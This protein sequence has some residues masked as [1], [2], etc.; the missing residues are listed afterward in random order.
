MELKHKKIV[1]AGDSEVGYYVA[2]NLRKHSHEVTIIGNGGEQM[3]EFGR[4]NDISVVEG[5]AISPQTQRDAKV[6]GC[7]Y[8]VSV[9]HDEKYNLLACIIAHN[10]GAK[11][12]VA[13]VASSEMWLGTTGKMFHGIGVNHMICPEDEAAKEI[14]GLLDFDNENAANLMDFSGG[15]LS[16]YKLCVQEDSEAANMQIVEVM[17]RNPSLLAHAVA[18]VRQGAETII[19][20]P[21]FAF[22]A[23]DQVYVVSSPSSLDQVK[24]LIGR[25]NES[26]SVQ[27]VI[28]AG[29]GRVGRFAAEKLSS[30]KSLKII[31][32]N[33]S[34]CQ[35]LAPKYPNVCVLRGDATDP[36]FLKSEGIATTDAFVA[37][38]NSSETNILACLQAK[39]LGVRRTIALVDNMGFVRISNNVGIT[40]IISK[41]AIMASYIERYTVP[42][43]A[44]SSRMLP[45]ADAEVI[46]V[47]VKEGAIATRFAYQD[48]RMPQGAIVGA[49]VRGSEVVIPRGKTHIEKGDTVVLFARSSVVD[50]AVALFSY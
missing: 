46:S 26:K 10:C 37:V 9:F 5:E 30:K 38:T 41:R 47:E 33:P 36:N 16:L 45:D 3:R 31:E 14:V 32:S 40:N 48:L 4:Y 2:E 29:G 19:P 34:V 18:V 44:T 50:D 22:A 43:Y 39:S 11:E 28:I 42:G 23:K 25:S 21:T 24:D 1:I 12:T 15:L 6:N 7:D 49:F 27:R 13:R 17:K 20:N 35:M 8:F